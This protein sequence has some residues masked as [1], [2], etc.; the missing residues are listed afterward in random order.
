MKTATMCRISL[1]IWAATAAGVLLKE[2]MPQQIR[3]V[4]KLGIPAAVT[5]SVLAGIAAIVAAQDRHTDHLD[6]LV[7]QVTEISTSDKHRLSFLRGIIATNGDTPTSSP[8][9]P[10]AI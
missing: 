3:P 10:G 7:T 8:A 6:Q 2:V 9:F 4:L 1:G 5:S